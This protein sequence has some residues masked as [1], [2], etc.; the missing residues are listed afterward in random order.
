MFSLVKCRAVHSIAGQRSPLSGS[1]AIQ[2]VR[3][4]QHPKAT[5]S[6][7]LVKMLLVLFQSEQPKLQIT[8]DLRDAEPDLF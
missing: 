5:Y 4:A 3:L 2:S 1:T 6:G 7:F 8:Q